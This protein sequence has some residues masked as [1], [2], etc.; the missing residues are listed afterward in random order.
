M[1][2]NAT[3]IANFKTEFRKNRLDNSKGGNRW[4]TGSFTCSCGA[5]VRYKATGLW[6]QRI[7]CGSGQEPITDASSMYETA[8][9]LDGFFDRFFAWVATK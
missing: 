5:T 2:M 6:V 3:D 4:Y 9:S 8:T 1:K 7:E